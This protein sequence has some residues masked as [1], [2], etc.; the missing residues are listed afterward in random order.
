MILKSLLTV[1]IFC[2]PSLGVS[3]DPGLKQSAAYEFQGCPGRS[4][5]ESLIITI[6][7]EEKH[8][9]GYLG[10]LKSIGRDTVG[11]IIPSD[12]Y[13]REIKIQEHLFYFDPGNSHKTTLEIELS[14][15]CSSGHFKFG[16]RK[17]IVKGGLLRSDNLWSI[18]GISMIEIN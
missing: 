4:E 12:F 6:L 13:A 10:S 1:L 18:H 16:D 7:S 8:I 9:K 2:F 5:E 11:L 14:E 3:D 17:Y 15:N